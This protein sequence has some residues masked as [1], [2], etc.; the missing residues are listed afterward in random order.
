MTTRSYL[1]C[2]LLALT[3]CQSS[4]NEDGANSQAHAKTTS[5]VAVEGNPFAQNVDAVIEGRKIY[6]KYGCAGCHG[7]GGGGGMGKPIIDDT[8]IFGGDDKTLFKLV[9]GE[10][11][12]QTMP[13][14]LGKSMSD[15]E[16][17][18]VL[19][20]VRSIY[21]GDPGA[22]I[23]WVAPPP[24][25]PEKLAAA[26]QPAGDAVTAG[27]QIFAQVCTPCHGEGGKGDGPAAAALNPKPRNLT[28]PGYLT[29]LDDRYL[30][31]LISRGG[32]AVGKSAMMPPQP[33]LAASDIGN[34]VAFVK[35][36]SAQ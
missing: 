3:G 22:I 26:I 33:S 13:N 23:G 28:E 27:K 31:E 10:I 8:W 14:T 34:V 1:V 4:K 2:G 11:P 32:V 17:W 16:I 18:K 35:T 19:V 29:S 20:Y 6:L 12:N 24:V 30:F 5:G 25:P 21:A 15:E 7:L 36:L 9:R